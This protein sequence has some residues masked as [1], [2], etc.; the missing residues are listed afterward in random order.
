LN[1]PADAPDGLL[2]HAVAPMEGG[3]MRFWEVWESEDQMRRFDA[4]ALMPVLREMF[5]DL[6]EPPR[7]EIAELHFVWSRAG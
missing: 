2:Y 3:G 4:G 7:E 1:F 6:G 5:D